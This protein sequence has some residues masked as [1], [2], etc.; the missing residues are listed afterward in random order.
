MKISYLL[1]CDRGDGSVASDAVHALLAQTLPPTE[2]IVSSGSAID[3][4]LWT[5]IRE[6]SGGSPQWRLLDGPVGD[7]DFA[8]IARIN[9]MMARARGDFVILGGLDKHLAPDYIA[10]LV[11]CRQRTGAAVIQAHIAHRDDNHVVGIVPQAPLDEPPTCDTVLANEG[12]TSTFPVVLAWHRSIFDLFGPIDLISNPHAIERTIQFRGS[13]LGSIAA[14]PQSFVQ[15][16]FQCEWQRLRRSSRT[17]DDQDRHA[18]I[19]GRLTLVLSLLRTLADFRESCAD[20]AEMAEMHV[21]LINQILRQALSWYQVRC[22][23]ASCGLHSCWRHPPVGDVTRCAPWARQEFEQHYLAREAALA[24]AAQSA[25]EAVQSLI[26]NQ[27]QQSPG[28]MRPSSRA[29]LA[30]LATTRLEG[31]VRARTT[32]IQLGYVEHWTTVD[33]SSPPTPPDRRVPGCHSS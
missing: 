5:A 4:A 14:L 7:D 18:D 1:P 28:Q 15:H 30:Q 12:T 13:L 29:E 21:D 31:W 19:A 32:L 22:Q 20:H 24:D 2:V 33:R 26:K 27:A 3:T 16:L 17:V 10:G 8:R 11:H 23:L 25:V 9:E 6:T